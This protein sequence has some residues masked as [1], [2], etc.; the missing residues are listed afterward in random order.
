MRAGQTIGGSEPALVYETKDSDTITGFVVG[1]IASTA[2][3]EIL[4][5]CFSGAVKSLMDRR[6]ARKLGAATE[7]T[8]KVTDAQINK[9]KQTKLAAMKTEIA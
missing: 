9:E 7:D 5:T 1:H 2:R 4:F 3:S 8:T 6:L